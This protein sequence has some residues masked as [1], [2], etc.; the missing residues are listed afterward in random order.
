[1]D[2]VTEIQGIPRALRQTLEVARR[3]YAA[4]V[5]RIRWGDGP[6]YICLCGSSGMI[7]HAARY[8]FE[9]IPGWPVIARPLVVFEEY[10]QS[11]L[12]PRSVLLI[13]SGHGDE[14]AALTFAQKVRRRGSTVLLFS[15]NPADPLK[16]VAEGTLVVNSQ[17]PN[18]S[19]ASVVCDLSA[20]H[21]LATL[22]AKTLKRP[23]PLWDTID[24]EFGHLPS[25]I[26][27]VLVQLSGAIRSLSDEVTSLSN[28]WIVGG[29]FYHATAIRASRRVRN[30]DSG[31]WRSKPY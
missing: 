27:W 18:G 30:Q 4:V 3:D 28:L 24:A 14:A 25:H 13:V 6:I 31:C 2:S 5:R 23:N 9:S 15:S 16:D 29:G 19:P 20:L 7:G 11:L 21:Y 12:A 22:T 10:S 8:A 26:E 17:A 1:M